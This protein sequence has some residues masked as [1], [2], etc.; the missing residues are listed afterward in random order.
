[1]VN[2]NEY[3]WEDLKVV[4]PGSTIPEDGVVELE[5]NYKKEH[6]NI[7]GRGAK[8]VA[9]GRGKEEMDGS[10]TLLQSTVE[11][12]QASLPAGKN[13]THLQPFTIT[14]SYA[15]E[16]GKATTDRLLYCRFKELPKGMKNGDD[17]ME[18]KIPLAI[19]DILY[20]V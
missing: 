17:H 10:I 14:A 6:T 19:G 20:N 9:T 4:L 5:Y 2:G 18:I 3:A 13:I 1:M 16:G 8:P 15:P 7:Y 11:A 12:L